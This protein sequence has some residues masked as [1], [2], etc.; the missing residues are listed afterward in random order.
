VAER[1]DHA[2]RVRIRYFAAAKAAAGLESEAVELTG[3]ATVR[4]VL[5][6]GI[7]RH[8]SRLAEVLRRCSFLLGEIAVHGED[9]VVTDGD[10]LDVLPP[11]AGG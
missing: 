10:V 5:Q 2:I 4:D 9:S 7:E 8:G 11:F 3:P 6:A 1:A